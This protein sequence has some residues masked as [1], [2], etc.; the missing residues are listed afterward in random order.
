MSECLLN[1]GQ[2]TEALMAANIVLSHVSILFDVIIGRR[3]F[4]GDSILDGRQQPISLK[5]E[6]IQRSQRCMASLLKNK[7]R[8]IS[9]LVLISCS[10]QRYRLFLPV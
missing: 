2:F 8:Q 6:G 7:G 4:P 9:S 1:C 3:V 10:F 5:G